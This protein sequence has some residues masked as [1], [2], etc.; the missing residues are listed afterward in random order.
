MQVPEAHDDVTPVAV[1]ADVDSSFGEPPPVVNV[2][3]VI[4]TFQP[5]PEPVASRI[6]IG[7]V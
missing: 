3:E 6:V 2:V 7:R 5:V 1:D 4:V